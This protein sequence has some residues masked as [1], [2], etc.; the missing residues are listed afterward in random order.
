MNDLALEERLLD[1]THV[2]EGRYIAHIAVPCRNL[3]EAARWYA[4]VLGAEPVRILHDRVTFS[5]G[6]VLQ[7]VCHLE[8]RAIEQNPRAYPRHFGL[9]FLKGEDFHRMRDHVEK[10]GTKL[11]VRPAMRF[12]GTPHEHHTFMLVDPSGNVLEFKY[13]LNPENS[14]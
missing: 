8:R 11:L 9:T 1:N 13:Y 3:Q 10:L 6:G 14:Y 12:A 7:L 2:T 4:E 5:F